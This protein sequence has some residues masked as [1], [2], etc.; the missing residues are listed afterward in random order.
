MCFIRICMRICQWSHKCE[1]RWQFVPT[2][3]DEKICAET[4]ESHW[5]A[6]K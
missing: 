2:S 5:S 3:G 1:K 6:V 4:F